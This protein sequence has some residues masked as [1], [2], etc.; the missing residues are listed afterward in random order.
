MPKNQTASGGSG[1]TQT[2][3]AMTGQGNTRGHNRRRRKTAHGARRGTTATTG[4][5]LG[6]RPGAESADYHRGR[7][8]A[9]QEM[10]Q[11]GRLPAR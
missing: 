5:S 7:A 1:T 9:F 11:T 6:M 4:G 2:G 3:G 10:L 8:S